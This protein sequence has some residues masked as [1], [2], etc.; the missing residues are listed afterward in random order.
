MISNNLLLL[1]YFRNWN[2]QVRLRDYK[3]VNNFSIFRSAVREGEIGTSERVTCLENVPQI[4]G[5]LVVAYRTGCS[6]R[7]Y[8]RK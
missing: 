6:E 8:S 1:H 4:Q 7:K 5:S 2:L 3:L